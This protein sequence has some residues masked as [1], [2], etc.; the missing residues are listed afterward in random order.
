MLYAKTAW[1]PA[2]H[3]ASQSAPYAMM[4]AFYAQPAVKRHVPAVQHIAPRAAPL[5]ALPTVTGA[6]LAANY[7]VL[8]VTKFAAFV[9]T[10]YAIHMETSASLAIP[11]F[12]PGT[13]I[14]AAYATGCSAIITY[15]GA[16]YAAA[17]CAVHIQ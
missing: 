3:A 16:R 15:T 17:T 12:A 11:T 2:V 8:I 7:T 9:I 6:Q 13:R 4:K 10:M 1:K 14:N 5:S